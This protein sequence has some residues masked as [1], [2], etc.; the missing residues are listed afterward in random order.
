MRGA[1][2]VVEAETGRSRGCLVY[3][4]I[5]DLLPIAYC[6]LLDAFAAL[7][8]MVWYGWL[9]VALSD[10]LFTTSGK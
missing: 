4:L 1:E 6:P 9:I 2:P 5:D 8:G 3:F 10:W 7:Y